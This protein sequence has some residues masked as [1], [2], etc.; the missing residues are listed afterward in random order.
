MKVN[1]PVIVEFGVWRPTVKWR[2]SLPS[3]N[4]SQNT[5]IHTNV[6]KCGERFWEEGEEDVSHGNGCG[7]DLNRPT[8][9]TVAGL[10]LPIHSSSLSM[11]MTEEES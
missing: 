11:Y 8:V 7:W 2:R 10:N 3:P 1:F 9:A 6:R 4:T 5:D